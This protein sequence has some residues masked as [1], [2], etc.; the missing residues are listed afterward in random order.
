MH[1]VKGK[2]ERGRGLRGPCTPRQGD[3]PLDPQQRMLCDGYN[4]R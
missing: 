1:V 3:D 2:N 4:K